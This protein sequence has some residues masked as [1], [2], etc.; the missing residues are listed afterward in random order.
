VNSFFFLQYFLKCCALIVSGF[1][2]ID[3]DHCSLSGE[4]LLF[5]GGPFYVEKGPFY[6]EWGPVSNKKAPFCGNPHQ[7][8][9]I[10]NYKPLIQSGQGFPQKGTPFDSVIF[11]FIDAARRYKPSM[12][13]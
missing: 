10:L 5:V 3:L 4:L 12:A 1:F 13:K 7:A 2:L 8:M 11:C 9:M 6:V